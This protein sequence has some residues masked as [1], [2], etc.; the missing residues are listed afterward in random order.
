[1]AKKKSGGTTAAPKT[2]KASASPKAPAGGPVAD[3]LKI[4][5]A[6]RFWAGLNDLVFPRYERLGYEGLTRA[7]QVAHCVDWLVRE[8]EGGGVRQFFEEPAGDHAVQTIESLRI[9]GADH[10]AELLEMV[11]A[12]FPEEIPTD[13]DERLA[14]ME[15]FTGRERR[16]F[17]EF[18]AAYFDNSENLLVLLK[19]YMG[20]HVGE[21][22]PE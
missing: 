5:N 13:Q 4:D 2:P 8:V 18:D 7:E 11:G 19:A 22:H 10:T 14:L 9:I 20:K 16:A 3:L 17:K 12:V 15:D 6:E 21:Y 1:M